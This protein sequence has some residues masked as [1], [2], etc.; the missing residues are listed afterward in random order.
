MKSSQKMLTQA[1]T[2]NTWFKYYVDNKPNK[3]LQVRSQ[4]PP[5]LYEKPDMYKPKNLL[6]Y[7][8]NDVVD[9]TRLQFEDERTSPLFVDTR[10][11][12]YSS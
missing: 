8:N 3:V 12:A 11:N 10:V 5:L 4:I 6:R 9:K 7:K 1:S 2:N